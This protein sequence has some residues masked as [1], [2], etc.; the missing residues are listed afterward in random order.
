MFGL[1]YKGF[2]ETAINMA[3]SKKLPGIQ[4]IFQKND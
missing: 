1:S 4:L 2:Y 3:N